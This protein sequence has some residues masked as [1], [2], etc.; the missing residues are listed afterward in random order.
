MSVLV[1]A[2]AV[3]VLVMVAMLMIGVTQAAAAAAGAFARGI[4]GLLGTGVLLLGA[5]AL[6]VG[7]V[8][9]DFEPGAAAE[10]S[11]SSTT[12]R[13]DKVPD[14]KHG[15]AKSGDGKDKR[16]KGSDKDRERRAD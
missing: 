7:L 14:R 2:L 12:E 5:A 1:F 8:I 4:T 9:V 3:S 11:R 10:P 15:K 16:A 6:L 13:P